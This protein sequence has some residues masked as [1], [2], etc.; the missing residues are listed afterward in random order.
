MDKI[1]N[2]GAV[3]TA[4]EF[5]ERRNSI[6]TNIIIWDVVTSL[7]SSTI[8]I[9]H[10]ACSF[11]DIENDFLSFMRNLGKDFWVKSGRW[12]IES[13]TDEISK[14]FIPEDGVPIVDIL[15][16]KFHLFN[17]SALLKSL[18]WCQRKKREYGDDVTLTLMIRCIVGILGQYI[19]NCDRVI[20][21][22]DVINVID[23]DIFGFLNEKYIE[24]ITQ[25]M[26]GTD[27]SRYNVC[28]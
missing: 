23:T 26:L 8:H 11:Q 1:L 12:D 27:W 6:T 3:P 14:E 10:K 2:I 18:L 17:V 13:F 25:Y 20:L 22:G 24:E 19:M 4:I 28:T 15:R 21:K 9:T 16:T 7:N 5:P